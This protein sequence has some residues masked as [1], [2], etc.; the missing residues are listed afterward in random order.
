LIWSKSFLAVF[1]FLLGWSSVSQSRP[2]IA[3]LSQTQI[4]I[5][6]SF[7]GTH[8]LL[9]GAVSEPGDIIVV[10]RGPDVPTVV[11]KKKRVGGIWVNGQGVNF[12]NAPGFYL[13]SSSKPLP[14]IA[15]PEILI[16]NSI[17]YR[18]FEMLHQ[19]E[20]RTALI[21]LKEL[22]GL[23]ATKSGG[24]KITD[25]Q[26]FQAELNFP[27]SVPTGPYRVEV[28]LFRQGVLVDTYSKQF[29]VRKVGLEEA[30]F[31][32]AH[33][34]SAIYGIMAIILAVIAGWAAGVC[35]RRT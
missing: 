18:S 10:V 7:K 3:D 30:V 32:F 13:I 2:L 12:E 1:W 34:H 31:R 19:G 15:K 28:H 24:V 6:T 25:N 16:E 14:K 22:S 21:R 4:A 29:R 17:G 23:Y 27:S 20:Y 9:F 11:R 5:T 33:T 26:L 35:F 8:L